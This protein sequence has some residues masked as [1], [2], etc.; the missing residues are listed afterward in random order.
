M[1]VGRPGRRATA[2]R[3]DLLFGER[4]AAA[5]GPHCEGRPDVRAIV[6]PSM[7][8]AFLALDRRWGFL[9]VGGMAT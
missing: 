5:L 2:I 1:F 6:L 8:V 7:P 3:G 9:S 4:R